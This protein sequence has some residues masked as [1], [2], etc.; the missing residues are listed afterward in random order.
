MDTGAEF[1]DRGTICRSIRLP[2]DV[3]ERSPN[4]QQV[5]GRRQEMVAE[6]WPNSANTLVGDGELMKAKKGPSRGTRGL[7]KQKGGRRSP[8]NHSSRAGE[9]LKICQRWIRS[10]S[11]PGPEAPWGPG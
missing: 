6:L 9:G 5:D 11:P 4:A 7:Y 3:Q 1:A 2:C 8:A 10:F